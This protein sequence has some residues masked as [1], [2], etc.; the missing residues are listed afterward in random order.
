MCT[1]MRMNEYVWNNAHH[2]N[3][4]QNDFSTTHSANGAERRR[5]VWFSLQRHKNHFKSK[6]DIEIAAWYPHIRIVV[7]SFVVP[8]PIFGTRPRKREKSSL[9]VVRYESASN[10]VVGH[11]NRTYICWYMTVGRFAV[12]L[13]PAGRPLDSNLSLP[14]FPMTSLSRRRNEHTAGRLDS[15]TDLRRG[16]KILT[17]NG[18]QLRKLFLTPD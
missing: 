12:P 9:I 4:A 5:H 2:S 6:R 11:S 10:G 8:I 1:S 7:H 15:S 16:Y 13:G 17:S 18:G 3:L 14:T